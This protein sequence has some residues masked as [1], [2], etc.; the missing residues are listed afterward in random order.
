[1]SALCGVWH[2]QMPEHQCNPDPTVANRS[3]FAG[4][5]PNILRFFYLLTD[6][7]L[8]TTFGAPIWL[9]LKSGICSK[10]T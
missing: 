4:G 9:V 6:T 7:F 5:N 10:M 1:M 8:G 3:E 2:S